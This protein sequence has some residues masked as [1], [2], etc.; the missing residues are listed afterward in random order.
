MSPDVLL[1]TARRRLHQVTARDPNSRP[2]R[3]YLTRPGRRVGGAPADF[4]LLSARGI[5]TGSDGRRRSSTAP[6]RS[7]VCREAP[8]SRSTSSSGRSGP[9]SD[10]RAQHGHPS[11]V[12]GTSSL[13]EPG[14]RLR[15]HGLRHLI[16]A[17]HVFAACRDSPAQ[18]RIRSCRS[19]NFGDGAA[20]TADLT[21]TTTPSAEPTPSG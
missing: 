10:P 4:G 11:G 7:G 3:D 15:R 14:G 18:R 2:I 13:Q 1:R 9:T 20:A 21:I 6:P 12:S 8:C 16:A 19:W 17:S 5:V